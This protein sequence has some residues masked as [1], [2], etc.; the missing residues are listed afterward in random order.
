MKV[1]P[2]A[3]AGLQK[4]SEP[5]LPIIED[6]SSYKLDKTNSV[7]WEL[8]TVPGTNGAATYKFQCRILQGD[9]TQR[10]IL[11][12][13]RG[14][15]KVVTGLNVTTVQTGVLQGSD[16]TRAGHHGTRS[17]SAYKRVRLK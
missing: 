2:T 13:L 8:S 15:T 10:Q 4:K 5:L 14:V 11:C 9:E 3:T 1:A 12:W 6:N 17:M 7:T 16:G